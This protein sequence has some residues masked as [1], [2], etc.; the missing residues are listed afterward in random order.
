MI[1]S[2][3]TSEIRSIFEE[4]VVEGVPL[5]IQQFVMRKLQMLNAAGS[6]EDLRLVAA[7]GEESELGLL[8]I[9]ID[10]HASISFR[11]ENGHAYD[12]ALHRHH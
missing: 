10:R 9:V 12:V 1:Q 5:P 11:W 8:R 6:I 3:A 7:G 2:F 4:C